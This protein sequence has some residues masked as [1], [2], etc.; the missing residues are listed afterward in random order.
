M[1][2]CVCE[3][4]LKSYFV[5]LANKLQ[6]SS[7]LICASSCFDFPHNFDSP[8]GICL[9]LCLDKVKSPQK[10]QYKT[11]KLR[12]Q[13]SML[14]KQYAFDWCGGGEGVEKNKKK[15]ARN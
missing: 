4:A 2:L 1:C 11:T 15:I 14:A 12:T 13:R 5:T 7:K 10:P 8:K 9:F 3:P 6:L